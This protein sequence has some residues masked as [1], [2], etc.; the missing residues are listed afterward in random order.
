[1]FPGIAKSNPTGNS[2]LDAG[3]LLALV[4]KVFDTKS[5]KTFDILHSILVTRRTQTTFSY[6]T[7]EKENTVKVLVNYFSLVKKLSK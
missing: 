1:M 4:W 6:K 7:A 2:I 3:N 5:A